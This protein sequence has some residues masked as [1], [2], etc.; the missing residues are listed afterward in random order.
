MQKINRSTMLMLLPSV[1]LFLFILV[2]MAKTWTKTVANVIKNTEVSIS[3]FFELSDELEEDL[4]DGFYKKNA[5]INLNGW[6]TNLAGVN[7]LNER[8]KLANNYLARIE[9][10]V[11]TTPYTDCLI[12]LNDFLEERDIP[13]L[14]VLAPSSQSFYSATFLPGYG[15]EAGQNIDSIINILEEAGVANLDMNAWFEANGWTM[16]DVFFKTDHHWLPEAGLAATRCTM[17]YLSD[18]GLATYEISTL[19]EESYSVTILENWFLGSHGKR[20]GS[21]FAGVDDFSIYVPNFA[22]AYSYA[23][24][25]RDTTSWVYRDNILDMSYAVATDYFNDNVYFT[26]MYA[27]YPLR[28]TVNTEA[29]NEGTILVIGDS[30]KVVC[31]YFLTTQFQTVYTIDLRYYTDGTLAEFVA[32]LQPDCVVMYTNSYALVDDTLY[33]FGVEEFM[34]AQAATDEAAECLLLGD[35]SVRASESETDAYTVVYA[36]LKPGHTYTLTVDSTSYDGDADLFVQMTL[37]NL[38]QDEAVYNRYF[39]AN[40]EDSQVWYFTVPEAD[41]EYALCLYAGTKGNTQ[42]VTATVSAVQLQEG[43]WE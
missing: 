13:F 11:D 39:D 15:C 19:A 28:I 22:T 43:I 23:A 20:T 29:Y 42:G 14:Y 18:C 31:E 32:E 33:E 1:V 6:V 38:T 36:D 17:E 26:Y 41:E 16:E 21:L 24:L 37:Q 2:C 40:S 30:Y 10:V 4:Q 27:D 3:G 25:K 8:Y 7:T 35:F 9:E 5:F 12:A 34:A